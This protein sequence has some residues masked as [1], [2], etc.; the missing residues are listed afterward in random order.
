MK[1]RIRAGEHHQSR[2]SETIDVQGECDKDHLSWPQRAARLTRRMCEAQTVVIQPDERIV[3]TRTV[4]KVP[5]LYSEAQ[6]RTLIADHTLHELGPI[7]NICANWGM[8]LSQG[9][10]TRKETALATRQR[11][12][13]DPE[14][15]EFLNCA[16]ETID[17]VLALARRYA[18]AAR[19]MGRD[20]IA[21]VLERVPAQPAET[22]HEALQALRLC[23]AVLWLSGHYHC[24]F[25]RFD[26]YMWPYLKADL[27]AGR[28]DFAAAEELLAEFFISLHKD[29]DLYPGI[30]QGDNGQSLMLGGVRRDGRPGVNPL[31]AMVLRVSR[32]VV[33]IDPKINLRVDRHTDEQLLELATELTRIGLGFPQYANDEIVIPSLVAAGY[34]VEDARDYSVAACWEF[35]IP[36]QG[37]EVINIG[38]VSFPAATDAA[39]RA[40]LAAGDSF[41]RI[42]KRVGDNLQSQVNALAEANRKLMLPP[43]PYYSVLMNG[44]L[45]RGRDVSLGL[46]YNNFGIHGAASA[47]AADALAAVRTF[48]FDEKRVAPE[49][50]LCALETNFANDESLRKELHELA[51][52][53]G[54]HDDYADALLVKLFDMF[55]DACDAAGGNG[56]GGRYRAGSGSAMYHVWLAR[57]HAGMREPVVGATADG[58]K[59]GEFFSSSLAPSPDVTVRGPLS[60]LQSFAKIHYRRISNGGPLTMELSESLF[61]GRDV[62]HKVTLFIR[63]FVD[64]G[65]QQLQLNTLNVKTLRAAQRHPELHRNLVVRVWGWSAYFCELDENFQN[66][67]LGRHVHGE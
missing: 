9:L 27:D 64:S 28:L 14:A 42:M 25:G 18:E 62:I 15:V 48:V 61:R 51:P 12:G 50:L 38:A 24:G 44:C 37:M 23:H 21:G 7:S 39:I 52:K 59:A 45:E 29:S 53:V 58:R 43:A 67:I 22:F 11:L 2:V 60:V 31:T 5:A 55:A 54:N 32:K 35:I 65:C 49:R 17:A 36:G 46:K 30:Q 40:G 47:N 26:Q 10:V 20:D 63:A 1:R 56:R 34:D 19:Q 13:S 33:L 57:G 6:L 16:I 3:F 8:V 41:E 4:R 66:Q